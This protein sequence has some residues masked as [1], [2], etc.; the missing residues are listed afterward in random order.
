MGF[1]RALNGAL[2]KR[3]PSR[4]IARQT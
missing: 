1:E 4:A 2:R 3:Q